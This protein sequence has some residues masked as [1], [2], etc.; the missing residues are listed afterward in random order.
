MPPIRVFFAV[1]LG[2]YLVTEAW[3]LLAA[4]GQRSFGRR[5]PAILVA[6]GDEPSELH[7]SWLLPLFEPDLEIVLSSFSRAGDDD[8][9]HGN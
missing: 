8:R 4:H 3:K 5:K 7:T 6:S 1:T 2:V 9:V